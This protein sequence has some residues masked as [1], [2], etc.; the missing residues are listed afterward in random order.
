MSDSTVPTSPSKSN[1]TALPVPDRVAKTAWYTDRAHSSQ[2]CEPGLTIQDHRTGWVFDIHVDDEERVDT[3]SFCSEAQN[4]E[5]HL[6]PLR[7]FVERLYR[8]GEPLVDVLPL[9]RKEP[10][11]DALHVNQEPEFDNRE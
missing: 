5:E 2:F 7:G 11:L 9:V 3:F 8:P 1:P 10:G 4:L 6:D